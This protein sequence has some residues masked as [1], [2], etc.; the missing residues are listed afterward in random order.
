MSDLNVKDF[1]C[2]PVSCKVGIQQQ[3][4]ESY[5]M[6]DF[7]NVMF[8]Q[9][10]TVETYVMDEHKVW[11][12]IATQ[13]SNGD[14]KLDVNE[15]TGTKI[16]NKVWMNRLKSLEKRLNDQE[17]GFKR[18]SIQF[19]DYVARLEI[20]INEKDNEITNLRSLVGSQE[21]YEVSPSVGVRTEYA[22]DGFEYLWDKCKQKLDYTTMLPWDNLK[23][24][25]IEKRL[26]VKQNTQQKIW[27][28]VTQQVVQRYNGDLYSEEI[29][30]NSA[31]YL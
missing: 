12:S 13:T 16:S 1:E 24:G 6:C 17:R 15:E 8:S 25:A 3:R 19:A 28:S 2:M 11:N 14:S 4:V 18:R 29:Y 20:R 9:P 26:H 7:K 23:L 30:R 10:E 27:K 31:V 21:E 5:K 22:L